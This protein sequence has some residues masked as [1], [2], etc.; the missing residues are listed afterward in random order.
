MVFACKVKYPGAASTCLHQPT[1]LPQPHAT[2]STIIRHDDGLQV[3]FRLFGEALTIYDSI[4]V[5]ENDQRKS[6]SPIE[7]M[8]NFSGSMNKVYTLPESGLI[9]IY[10]GILPGFDALSGNAVLVALHIL[11]AES[12]NQKSQTDLLLR[13]ADG[14]WVPETPT[15][16]CWLKVLQR[17]ASQGTMFITF[18]RGNTEAPENNFVPLGGEYVSP[19]TIEVGWRVANTRPEDDSDAEDTKPEAMPV[20]SP[21]PQARLSERTRTPTGSV[22]M[23]DLPM[24]GNPT[25]KVVSAEPT[26]AKSTTNTDPSN[27]PDNPLGHEADH[28]SRGSG[29]DNS[30]FEPAHEQT[31]NVS[32]ENQNKALAPVTTAQSHNASGLSTIVPTPLT[33]SNGMPDPV[34]S[35]VGRLGPLTVSSMAPQSSSSHPNSRKRSAADAFQ[36]SDLP[37]RERIEYL[38][39]GVAE[40]QGRYR[41]AHI[42][43]LIM[44]R[45]IGATQDI[46]YHEKQLEIAEADHAL[47]QARLTLE[48]EYNSDKYGIPY[49]QVL[50]NKT[51]ADSHVAKMKQNVIAARHTATRADQQ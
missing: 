36:I 26:T 43:G 4:G 42:E 47:A 31:P 20:A 16:A 48:D 19:Y 13:N 1:K 8:G 17:E 35:I 46:S 25:K 33:G 34:S 51:S 7:H 22:S 28:V 41:T 3:R 14:T 49:L 21:T 24:L 5:E 50:R 2:M 39:L 15:G 12:H 32:E 23:Q 10:F 6:S 38:K 29:Q 30:S 18:T 44:A 45:R 37:L 11:N 27:N 40:A 9:N